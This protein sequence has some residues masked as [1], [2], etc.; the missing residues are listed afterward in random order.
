MLFVFG[1]FAAPILSRMLSNSWEGYESERRSSI[2]PNAACDRSLVLLISFFA[3]P[4]REDLAAQV[5]EEQPGQGGRVHPRSHHLAGPML[6]DY[7]D[8]GYLIWAMPEHPVF[9]DG[10]GDV[11]EWTGVLQEF[12][13][14]ATLETDPNTLLD[15]YDIQFCL[16]E[17]SRPWPMFFR[18]CPTGS[19]LLRCQS[20]IFVRTAPANPR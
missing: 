6:N 14:W 2:W 15:K 10:R 9:V 8:G 3:F 16:L 18:S 11:F 1:I 13:Q 19:R 4:S 20:V 12:G 7:T 5:A 17:S